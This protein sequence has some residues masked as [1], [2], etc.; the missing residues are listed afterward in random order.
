MYSESFIKELESTIAVSDLIGKKIPLRRRGRDFVA[1]CPFHHEKTPSFSVSDLKGIYHCFGCGKSGNIFTF[2]M[3]TEGMSFK[4]AV[5]H[6]A[7][8]YGI[9]L[10]VIEKSG[11]K[12]KEESDE[13]DLIYEINECTCK[14]FEENLY[15]TYG[16]S[17]L[18][19]ARKR[20]LGDEHIKKFR[21]GY[22]VDNYSMLLKYLKSLNYSEKLIEK[23]GVIAKNDT[24]TY[25]DKF[26]NRLMF[27][28]LNK[29]GQVIAF[30]GRVFG[31]GMPKYMNSPETKIY[32]KGNVLFNYFFAKKAIYDEKSVVLVEGNMDALSL[33]ING[34][35]NVVAPMGTA[36]TESQIKELWSVTDT[37]FVCLDGDNAGK[38]A[39]ERL[40]KLVLPIISTGK[41][42]KFVF[43][44]NDIDPDDFIKKFGRVE[45]DKLLKS[46]VSLSDYI[47]GNEINNLNIDE[48][49]EIVPE[50][51]A[52]LEK[53]ISIFLELIKDSALK[54]HFSYF[55]KNKLW[56]LGRSYNK[57]G[58]NNPLKTEICL[59][60]TNIDLIE[61]KEKK[62]CYLLI[63]FPSL[64]SLLLEKYNIDIF[65]VDFVDDECNMVL[66]EI[67]KYLNENEDKK[68]EK[69]L[70]KNEISA[71][72]KRNNIFFNNSY[73]GSLT[74]KKSLDMINILLLE[75]EKMLLE[76]DLKEAS[77]LGDIVKAKKLSDKLIDLESKINAFLAESSFV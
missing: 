47:W 71:Y 35:E 7:N 9:T 34:V 69:L 53:N 38:K 44:P 51:K 18:L 10:P 73:T 8:L 15:K 33:S 2:I 49:S 40:S 67:E 14:F 55:Y 11:V 20:G 31:D 39:S 24:G 36:I 65:S 12:N 63:S 61:K 42:I 26:R 75:K 58:N 57:K 21:I 59:N 5:E 72:I 60:K 70:V 66:S 62:I 22:A 46:S 50:I 13:I 25:Y 6:I 30:T 16:G 74:E 45:F 4:E 27:P 48:Q 77:N 32:K 56:N 28:V 64:V 37:I 43:L 41:N 54:N 29:K 17:A 52:H 19:Y 23:S 68:L 3:E 76:F 1:C